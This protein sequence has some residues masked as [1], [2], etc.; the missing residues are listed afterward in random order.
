MDVEH[1]AW[2]GPARERV[3]DSRRRGHERP[4]AEQELLVAEH[5]LGLALEDVERV[6]V[7][8]V[9]VRVRPVEA[10]LE[11]ELDQRELLAP[12]LDRCDPIGRLEPLALTCVDAGPRRAALAAPGRNVDAVEAA[13]LAAIPGA[14]VGREAFVRGVEVE[15]SR[16]RRA[17][18]PVDDTGGSADACAWAEQVL[19]LPDE[20]RELAF[21]DVER[22]GVPLMKVWVRPGRGRGRTATP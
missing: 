2:P 4:C 9:R 15:E 20:E 6:D 16:P 3:H 11:L 14:Q 13:R 18:E 22:V 19:L 10:R 21:E 17:P 1:T 5:E 8:V 12:D 7:V